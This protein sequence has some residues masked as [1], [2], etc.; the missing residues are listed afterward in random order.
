MPLHRGWQGR[1]QD[2]A[3]YSQIDPFSIRLAAKS[4]IIRS[5]AGGCVMGWFDP[6]FLVGIVARELA[7]FAAMGFLF[8]GLDDLAIDLI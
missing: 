3:R 5:N 1:G 7:L 4:G 2:R 6:V 8:G